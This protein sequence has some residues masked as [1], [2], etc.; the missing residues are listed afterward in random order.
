MGVRKVIG[1]AT[2]ALAAGCGDKPTAPEQQ[3]VHA[4]PMVTA[5]DGETNAHRLVLSKLV[6]ARKASANKIIPASND[7]A[8]LAVRLPDGRVLP[9]SEATAE[10]WSKA[11]AEVMLPYIKSY[12]AAI[13]RHNGPFVF[14]DEKRAANE[15]LVREQAKFELARSL[16]QLLSDND[17]KVVLDQLKRDLGIDPQAE[18][19]IP[20][21]YEASEALRALQTPV[22]EKAAQGR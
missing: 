19:E 15:A 8:E 13:K 9:L 12:G 6:E 3:P 17:K 16:F 22:Q 1:A 5:Q 20:G 10:E 11:T 18:R 2:L 21:L 14:P 7:I 4:T